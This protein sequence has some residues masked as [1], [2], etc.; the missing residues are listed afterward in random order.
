MTYMKSTMY[1]LIQI[2]KVMQKVW[3][4]NY[5]D[6]GWN[7]TKMSAFSGAFQQRISL[8]IMVTMFSHPSSLTKLCQI[9][10]KNIWHHEFNNLYEK[11]TNYTGN[12]FS[13]PQVATNV[14]A[15]THTHGPLKIYSF[16][17]I[18][19]KHTWRVMTAFGFFSTAKTF[20]LRPVSS[21]A[22]FITRSIMTSFHIVLYW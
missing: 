8:E 22:C 4:L 18:K 12:A 9:Y 10:I 11:T 15:R 3:N 2:T 19:H 6:E 7:C 21:A 5:S 20:N 14:R 1:K 17:V 16:C 13:T